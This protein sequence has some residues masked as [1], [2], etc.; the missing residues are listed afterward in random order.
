MTHRAAFVFFSCIYLLLGSSLSASIENGNIAIEAHSREVS[1]QRTIPPSWDRIKWG[2]LSNGFEYA[3]MENPLPEHAVVLRLFVKAG[4]VMESDMQQGIA[5]FLEHMAFNGS[6]HF[7]KGELVEYLQRMGMSFGADTN[8]CTWFDSTIYNLNLPQNDAE[9]I[10][11][12]LEI[13]HDFCDGLLLE[14]TEINRERG[15]VLSEKRDRDSI[16]YRIFEH[17]FNF[18]LP[19][20]ILSKRLPIGTTDCLAMANHDVMETFYKTNY[21]PDRMVLVVVGQIEPETFI[22]LIEKHFGSL[23]NP[24]TLF[25]EPDLGCLPQ[26]LLSTKVHREREAASTEVSIQTI[27]PYLYKKDTVQNRIKSLQAGLAHKMLSE[28][29]AVMMRRE[30]NPFLEASSVSSSIL[31]E[32]EVVSVQAGCEPENWAS[33]LNLIEQELRRALEYGFSESEL[34]QATANLLM[35]VENA[36]LQ[37]GTTW[38]YDWINDILD[39]IGNDKITVS[40]EYR[41]KFV[42]EFIAE[43]RPED[44]WNAFK[45]SWSTESRYIFVAGNVDSKLTEAEV[46]EVYQQS[47]TQP[48][49][50]PEVKEKPEFAYV[51]WGIPGTIVNHTHIEDL[52]I[53]Q[54]V[55][56]NNVYLNLK[57]TDFSSNEILVNIRFGGGLLDLYNIPKSIEMAADNIFLKGGLQKHSWEDLEKITAGRKVSIN[58]MI[59]S[60]CMELAGVS[61]QK[62]LM[63]QLQLLAAYLQEPGFRSE[64]LHQFKRGIEEYDRNRKHTLQGAI[65]HYVPY[66]ITSEDKRYK[67]PEPE[68][69]KA[70]TLQAVENWLQ[71]PLKDSMLEI[72][73]VGDFDIQETVGAVSRTFGTLPKRLAEKPA[74]EAARQL[75]FPVAPQKQVFKFESSLP[76]SRIRAYWKTD[77]GF[78]I[79]QKR[80]LILL[81]DIIDD[82]LRLSARQK[83]GYA[84]SPGASSFNSLTFPKY[85]YIQADVTCDADKT[86]ELQ[87][88]IASIAEDIGSNGI[89]SDELVRVVNPLLKGLEKAFKTN[90]Y[91]IDMLEGSHEYPQQFDWHRSV[92]KDYESIQP[93]NIHALAQAF[94]K[95]DNTIFVTITPEARAADAEDSGGFLGL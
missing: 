46:T 8:A 6:R 41:L 44:C 1:R 73:I 90:T 66:F 17:Y 4:S 31:N 29:F 51:D 84:Y 28:R 19:E 94:L 60:D 33:S 7:E 95:A 32:F 88:L 25:S 65:S 53:H 81:A 93:E 5:H 10:E 64:A 67:S 43:V 24:D 68:E 22:P 27:R 71:Q 18:I 80:K 83:L 74:Y 70:I 52:D 2:K 63:L 39:S 54:Y 20:S 21:R 56:D 78:D 79:Q 62:D 82:R 87:F 3:V 30:D 47:L 48:V 59:G 58:F 26:T 38:S 89:T 72:S 55:F 49:A 76:K 23:E 91:W 86:D 12:G 42:K 16:N 85:G 34:N 50:A 14:E 69:L 11:K 36:V 15:V 75:S 92:V 40:P 13:F 61:N 77:D 45:D 37:E 35:S 9:T 57:K